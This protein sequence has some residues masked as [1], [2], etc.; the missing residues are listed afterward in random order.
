MLFTQNISTNLEVYI[1]KVQISRALGDLTMVLRYFI[2]W[3]DFLQKEFLEN[4]LNQNCNCNNLF[5]FI[6]PP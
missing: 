1:F 3:S 5:Y 2:K 6:F 4:P